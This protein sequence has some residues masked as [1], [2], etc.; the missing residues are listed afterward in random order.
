MNTHLEILAIGNSPGSNRERL[1]LEKDIE[2]SQQ[3][4]KPLAKYQRK[5]YIGLEK[6]LL[7]GIVIKYWLLYLLICLMLKKRYPKVNPYNYLARYLIKYFKKY[8][9]YSIA[10]VLETTILVGTS[11]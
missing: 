7:I 1:Q 10:A 6:Q 8:L 2:V 4:L 9:S 3:Y 5:R 11:I